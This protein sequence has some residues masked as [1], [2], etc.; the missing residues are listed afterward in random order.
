MS[1]HKVVLIPPAPRMIFH[2]FTSPTLL[3]RL[4]CFLVLTSHLPSQ[5]IYPAIVKSN[6]TKFIRFTCVI[7]S[8]VTFYNNINLNLL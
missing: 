5:T 7:V 4:L 1:S 8:K 6:E 3:I 2:H